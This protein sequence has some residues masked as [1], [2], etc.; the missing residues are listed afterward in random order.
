M[1]PQ[2]EV[3][4]EIS[5]RIAPRM[6]AR[7]FAKDVKVYDLIASY[8]SREYV[9]FS[10]GNGGGDFMTFDREELIHTFETKG[11]AERFR[12]DLI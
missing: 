10:Y 7:W 4:S 2:K 11:E 12:D 1:I 9:D 8:T 6:K 5:Y 3:V